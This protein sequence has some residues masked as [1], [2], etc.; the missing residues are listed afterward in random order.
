MHYRIE[1]SNPLPRQWM[2]LRASVGWASFPDD[3][4]EISLRNTLHCV[5]AYEN[6]ELIGMARV[7]GDG[8]F[9]FYVGNVMVHPNRQNEG[10]GKMILE[11]LLDWVD[12]HAYPGARA[13]LLSIKGKESF[14]EPFGFECRPD[15][16][17]GS[18][19]SKYY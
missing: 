1:E 12:K 3:I 8:V 16:T 15:E 19:M 9:T 10:I 4:V 6:D 18:G 5:C 2:K 7:L 14:Y 17:H 13:S 11:K